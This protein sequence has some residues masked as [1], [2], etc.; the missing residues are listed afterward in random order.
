M[1]RS[2]LRPK[3]AE[4][5]RLLR[6]GTSAKRNGPMADEH[7][8]VLASSGLV[9]SRR[10]ASWPLPLG[11]LKLLR[12]PIAAIL[13]GAAAHASEKDAGACPTDKKRQEKTVWPVQSRCTA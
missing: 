3:E 10:R 8:P 11:Y 12:T 4:R 1:C 6:H 7:E 2:L 5:S 9:A 13:C